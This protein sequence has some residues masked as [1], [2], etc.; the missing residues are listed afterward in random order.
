MATSGHVATTPYS[1]TVYKTGVTKTLTSVT[2]VSTTATATLVAH[3]FATGDTVTIAGADVANYNGNKVITVTS[4]DEFTYTVADSGA[5][6]ATGTITAAAHDQGVY[7][8]TTLA[9]DEQLSLAVG[10]NENWLVDFTIFYKNTDDTTDSMTASI[11]APTGARGYFHIV[12]DELA[13]A[14]AIAFGT[15]ID[16]GAD[17][18]DDTIKVRKL[19]AH[20]QNG[21]TAGNVVFQFAQTAGAPST[22]AIVKAGSYLTAT[23]QFTTLVV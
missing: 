4:A 10:A 19:R 20:V 15:G 11:A 5:S 1:F 8:D 18:L 23:Q 7:N 16:L 9:D 6:P 22:Q 14:K 21:A 3:G 17:S 13:A 12:S 2:R